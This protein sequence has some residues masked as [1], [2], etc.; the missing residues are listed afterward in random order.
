MLHEDYDT[1]LSQDEEVEATQEHHQNFGDSACF[2]LP[3]QIG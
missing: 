3:L 2:R 1:L